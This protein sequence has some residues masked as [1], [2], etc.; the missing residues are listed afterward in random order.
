MLGIVYAVLGAA[1]LYLGQ[2]NN[3][4]EYAQ[5]GLETHYESGVAYFMGAIHNILSQAH[6]SAENFEKALLHSETAVD[7]SRKAN[8]RWI[9]GES[10]VTLGRALAAI[11][12]SNFNEAFEKIF[13]GMNIFD[14]LQLKP[15]YA[16][17]LLRLGELYKVAGHKKET[18]ENVKKA[19]K[20][21][22]EMEMDYY[23]KKTQDVLE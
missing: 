18:I 3:A 4:L 1:Y 6:L 16:V 8:E 10:L 23:I 17:G 19:K 22:T 2:T 11:D 14:E 7:Q 20:M 5:R 9:E 13:E 12:R 21:F 15:L